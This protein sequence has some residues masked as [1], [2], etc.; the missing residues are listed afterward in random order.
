MADMQ[1]TLPSELEDFVRTRVSSGRYDSATAV[2]SEGLR[3]L[4]E[5]ERQRETALSDLRTLVAEGVAEADRGELLDGEAVMAELLQK[6]EE[7]MAEADANA[8]RSA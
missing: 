8:R 5:Q 4:K 7:R 3:L 1:I 6:H 2:V